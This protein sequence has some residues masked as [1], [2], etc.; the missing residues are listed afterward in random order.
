MKRLLDKL[1]ARQ[2]R[3]LS[4]LDAPEPMPV[5]KAGSTRPNEAERAR[6]ADEESS[7]L[8]DALQALESG[9]IAVAKKVLTPFAQ[10]AALVRTLTTLSRVFSAEGDFDEALELL[11]RA[12]GLD[13][14]DRKVWRLLAE[15]CALKG[16]HTD[17]VRYRRQL[18]YVDAGAPAQAFVELIR[19]I[20]RASPPR[21]KPALNE[22][23]TASKRVKEAPDLTAEVH[24]KF[25]EALYAF[26]PATAKEARAHYV[27]ARPCRTNERDVSA[28]WLRPLD[29]CEQSGAKLDRW[30]EGGIPSYRPAIAELREVQI[31][32]RFQWTPV[33]DN[34]RVAL[35]GFLV[36]RPQLRSEDPL[37]PLLMQTKSHLELRIPEALPVIEQP[38]LLLGGIGQYY[39]NTVECLSSLAI[40]ET[41]GIATDLPLVVNDDLAPFQIEQLAL[42]GYSQDRLIRVRSDCPV[43]FSRLFA[44]T[45]LVLGGQWLDPLVPRWYRR[46]YV[47]NLGA[48]AKDRRLYISRSGALKRRVANEEEL[49]AMLVSRGF[50]VVRPEELSVRA[51]IDLFAAA[52]CIVAPTGAALTNMLFAAPEAVVVALCNK[53]IVTGGGDLYFDAMA[54]ACGHTFIPIHCSPAR[55][56]SGQR[57]IDSDITVDVDAVRAA[58]EP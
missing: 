36:N 38:A 51:Q 13:P 7:A 57:V 16:L 18:A 11:K 43:Q 58:I 17:E 19:S 30:T 48:P 45:R 53:H 22:I 8:G 14:S 44:P 9:D 1:M 56:V 20:H 49:V 15:A 27:A 5:T 54:K 4:Q 26:G 24:V 29:W 12:E 42:L 21:V 52:T 40:A 55:V 46:R 47:S 33:V 23:R 28:R 41:L 34:G 25:A 3:L 32:P 37:T 39:H 50:E 2:Q 10:D 31:F 35:S 6:R